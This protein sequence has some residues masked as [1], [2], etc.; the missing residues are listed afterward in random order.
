MCSHISGISS[1][2]NGFG[3]M[4]AY[5]FLSLPK[6]LPSLNPSW[7]LL[8]QN[9]V[10]FQNTT[11]VQAT[12]YDA[13]NPLCSIPN[14]LFVCIERDTVRVKCLCQGCLAKPRLSP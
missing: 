7:G 9:T 5:A 11:A 10:I 2:L 12:V 4:L 1:Q 3:A 8:D 14:F 6:P 13:M